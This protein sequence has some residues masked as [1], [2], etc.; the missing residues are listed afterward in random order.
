MKIGVLALVFCALPLSA[1]AD[2]FDIRTGS[3]EVTTAT[4]VSGTLLPPGVLDQLSPAQRAK[5]EESAKARA[6]KVNTHTAR[7]CVTKEELDRNEVIKSDDPDCKRTVMSQSA[8]QLEVEE[9]CSGANPSKSHVKFD[10]K[11]PESY[12]ASL[13]RTTANGQFH[14]DVSG[15]WLGATCSKEDTD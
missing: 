2:R 14:G 5:I 13:D 4:T 10:S 11:S 6:G 15:K 1:Y 3:W 9:V 8:R 7:T 12:T